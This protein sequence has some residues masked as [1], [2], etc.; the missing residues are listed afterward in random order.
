MIIHNVRIWDGVS[1]DYD[2]GCD[3]IELEGEA[4]RAIGDMASLPSA[5]AASPRIDGQGAF[6]IPGLIDAHVHLCLDPAITDA[7]EHGRMPDDE[8]LEAMRRRA[9]AMVRAGITTARDLGGGR[10]LELQIRDRIRRGEIEGPRLLC[11]GQPITS[12]GGHC[13]FWGGEA[14]G[15][16]AALDVLARQIEHDVDL[17]KV[18]ATGGAITPGS[19]PADAQ[20]DATTITAVVLA[21]A[22]ADRHVAAH[23]HGTGGIENAAVGGVRTVEH[24]SWVGDRGWGKNFDPAVA[25]R[26]ASQDTWVS[27]T[28]NLGWKRRIGSGAYEAQIQENF[29]AMRRAGVRLIAST[30]AGIPGVEHHDLARALPVFAHF[31]GL[32]PVETLRAATS[33]CAEAIGLGTVTGRLAPGFAADFLLVDGNPL[34]SLDSLENPVEVVARGRRLLAA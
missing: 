26:M 10:W 30:D 2:A 18:M 11:A 25:A 29:A 16:D 24:C 22:R 21:A 1:D 8:L 34:D 17:I 19:T 6:V 32:S 12:V 7:F 14:D 31:A 28:I 15:A 33:E 4:I 20:F 23:C 5:S 27:P 9:S 13:H 3:A